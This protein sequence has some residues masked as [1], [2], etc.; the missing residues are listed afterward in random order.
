VIGGVGPTGDAI[1]RLAARLGVELRMVGE[2][3]GHDLPDLLGAADL[4]AYASRQGTNVPVAILEAMA[5]ARMVIATDQP[6]SAY[7]LLA[8]G[9]GI[10]VPAGEVGAY[11]EALATAVSMGEGE[12]RAAGDAAR[13]WIEVEHGPD[14]VAG[15]L[16]DAFSLRMV[17]PR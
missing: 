12:R 8:D 6:P 5:C 16:A 4:F 10:V 1:E 13:R 15:E 11:A 2:V 9:R 14:R 17:R 7:E 3:P